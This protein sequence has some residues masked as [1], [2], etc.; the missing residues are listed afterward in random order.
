MTGALVDLCGYHTHYLPFLGISSSGGRGAFRFLLKNKLVTI[1]FFPVWG[2]SIVF[3]LLFVF[4]SF[5]GC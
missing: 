1:G 3:L 4:G 5:L 2:V